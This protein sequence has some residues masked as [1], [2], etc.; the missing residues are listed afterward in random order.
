MIATCG[1]CKFWNRGVCTHAPIE[2]YK[3]TMLL[4]CIHFEL[5]TLI[6]KKE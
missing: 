6:V 3:D 1:V 5:N 4:T 2:L